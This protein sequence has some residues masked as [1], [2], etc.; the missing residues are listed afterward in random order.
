M[1]HTLAAHR[2]AIGRLLPSLV[3]HPLFSHEIQRLQELAEKSRAVLG[4]SEDEAEVEIASPVH[5]LAA[6][7]VIL[8]SRLGAEILRKRLKA[9]P[10]DWDSGAEAYFNDGGSQQHWKVLQQMLGD[11][12]CEREANEI[13]EGAQAAFG[14]FLEEANIAA[15]HGGVSATL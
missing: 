2:N 4:V 12:D 10:T 9:A 7:Y 15:R 13:V 6:A 3:S 5:P 11:I 8:G 14:V 1:A